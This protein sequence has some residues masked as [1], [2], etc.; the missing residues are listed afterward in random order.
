MCLNRREPCGAPPFVECDRPSFASQEA[1][2]GMDALPAA[3]HR[4]ASGLR[5]VE[6]APGP[7]P[8]REQLSAQD[9]DARRIGAGPADAVATISPPSRPQPSAASTRVALRAPVSLRDVF[10]WSRPFARG[11]SPG[12]HSRLAS[13]RRH[14]GG[15]ERSRLRSAVRFSDRRQCSCSS[16]RRSRPSRATR[17]SSGP[18]PIVSCDGSPSRSR[19]PGRGRGMRIADIGAGSG[20]GGLCAAA[21]ARGQELRRS[22]WPTSITVPCASAASMPR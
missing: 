11:R 14:G 7:T 1:L 6:S 9:R 3:L 22:C 13:R 21:S 8:A 16:I 5:H 10:G 18:T 2:F 19:P 17:S 20:A 15:D 12:G 4:S